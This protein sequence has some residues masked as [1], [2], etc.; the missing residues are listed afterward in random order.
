MI[1]NN[2]SIQGFVIFHLYS[3]GSTSGT[4]AHASSCSTP[5]SRPILSRLRTALTS[6]FEEAKSS[7]SLELQDIANLERLK[8]VIAGFE[9]GVHCEIEQIADRRPLL[10]I[11]PSKLKTYT[12][13]VGLFHP[14]KLLLHAENH[15]EIRV[16]IVENAEAGKYEFDDSDFLRGLVTKVSVKSPLKICPGLQEFK[17]QDLDTKLGYQPKKLFSQKWP[18][19]VNRHVECLIWHSP[20][21]ARKSRPSLRDCCERCKLLSRELDRILERRKKNVSSSIRRSAKSTHRIDVLSPASRKIRLQNIRGER[22][23]FRKIARKYWEKTKVHLNEKENQELSML[24][25]EIEASVQGREE[26]DNVF[27]EA[28]KSKKGRGRTLKEVWKMDRL[29]FLN[30]QR[31][32]GN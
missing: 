12:D 9:L 20:T 29:E 28:E 27:E 23:Y 17:Y 16:N 21:N 14:V 24:I 26:L 19:P 11:T 2:L 5:K 13:Y 1:F 6:K 18:W 25:S 3:L 7:K 15:Y 31:R 10:S 30:D 8:N 22:K 32:N 4:S